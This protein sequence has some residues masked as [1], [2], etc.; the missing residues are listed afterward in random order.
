MTLTNLR[1]IGVSMFSSFVS[2]D[3]GKTMRNHMSQYMIS[4][5]VLNRHFN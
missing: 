2:K 1:T 3:L 4:I 5:S